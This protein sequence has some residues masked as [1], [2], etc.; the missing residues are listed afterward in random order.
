MSNANMSQGGD[1]MSIISKQYSQNVISL[2]DD[3][4]KKY[5]NYNSKFKEYNAVY[6]SHLSADEI[7]L[8]THLMIKEDG[9]Y[10]TEF[11][12]ETNFH[13]EYVVPAINNYIKDSY[14]EDFKFELLEQVKESVERAA[15]FYLKELLIERFEQWERNH[16]SPDPDDYNYPEAA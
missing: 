8:I 6:I 1:S 3:V 11:A 16:H 5:V 7:S 4:V 12:A 13:A 10:L 15:V 9:Q 2:V 14:N